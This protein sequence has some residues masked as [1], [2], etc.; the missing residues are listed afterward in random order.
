MECPNCYPDTTATDC[1]LCHGN[2]FFSDCSEEI[3]DGPECFGDYQ[4]GT[5]CDFCEYQEECQ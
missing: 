2:Y 1:P 5:H 3:Q 4:P